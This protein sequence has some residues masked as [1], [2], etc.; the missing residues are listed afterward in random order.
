MLGDAATT[1]LSSLIETEMV[2][3]PNHRGQETALICQSKTEPGYCC[4]ERQGWSGS[5]GD[6]TLQMGYRTRGKIPRG[7]TDG[8]HRCC[9]I[10]TIKAI[11]DG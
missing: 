2:D 1:E 9:S 6:Q 7:E 3:S 10:Y 4:N 8:C 11:Q 5:H